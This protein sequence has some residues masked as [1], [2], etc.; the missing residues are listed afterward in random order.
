MS[1]FQITGG[2]RLI[3]EVD[4][5]GSKNIALALMSAVVLA[6]GVTI[7][8]NVPDVSDT[9]AKSRLLERC[10]VRVQ[11]REGSVLFETKGLTS[12]VGDDETSRSIRTSFYLLGPLLARTG[13]ASLPVPG[14]CAIGA[15]PV[16]FHLK[17]LALM[18]AEVHLDRGV[19]RAKTSGLHGAEIYLDFPSAGATQHL[20]AT[21]TLAQGPTVIQNAA[22]EPEVVALAEFLNHM[23]ARVEG[24]GTSTVTVLGVLSLQP[25]TFAVPSD[26]LQ[27]GTYLMAGAITRGDVTVRGVLPEHLTAVTNKLQQAGAQIEEGPDWVRVRVDRRLKSIRVKTMPYP[28]FSTDLQQPMAALLTLA[29][30]TSVVEET[31][32]E[33]RTGHVPELNRMGADI[34]IE[35]RSA[36]INGVESLQAATVE[37][38]D[39]RAGAALCLAALAADGQ[40]LI[41]NVHFIDRGYQGLEFSLRALGARIER[42]PDHEA[43]P[44]MEESASET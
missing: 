41:R 7:L 12:H 28:G 21:A 5:A 18:G 30:G 19:Y 10:G 35:G 20:M 1:Y 14:G 37:A 8:H 17:G 44:R 16:D 13:E 11:W 33:S 27:A 34:R 22:A 9:R 23:G 15:R 6:D 40:T 24:A 42:L 25:C 29:E 32:Y 36:V 3:G 43:V 2:P 38:S 31:I 26:R 4:V 39:L